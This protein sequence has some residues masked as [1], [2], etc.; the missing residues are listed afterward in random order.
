MSG[1]G[2]APARSPGRALRTL[3]GAN[4]VHLVVLALCFALG[5]YAVSRILDDPAVLTIAVWFVGAALVWDLV[6]G[7]LVALTDRALLPLRHVGALNFVRVPLLAGAL[8]L[9]VWAPVIFGRSEQTFRTKA[10][11][12]QDVFLGRWL[13]ITALLFAGSA[14]LYAAG[15]LRLRGRHRRAA[16]A[17]SGPVARVGRPVDESADRS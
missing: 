2:A 11:L 6:L 14:V 1:P 3:Y 16:T 17:G 5:L 13:V 7:P 15:R 8:L 4:P 12:G 10:G 9:L